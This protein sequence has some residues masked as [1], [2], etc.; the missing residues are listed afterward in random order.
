ML[1]YAAAFPRCRALTSCAVLSPV[2]PQPPPSKKLSPLDPPY[3]IKTQQVVKDK[4]VPPCKHLPC[5][6]P[7]CPP[8]ARRDRCQAQNCDAAAACWRGADARKAPLSQDVEDILGS[9]SPA[10]VVA[11]HK[12]GGRPL[13]EAIIGPHSP[14]TRPGYSRKKS[15]EGGGFFTG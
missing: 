12:N 5:P 15:E 9:T 4:V 14:Q 13:A 3:A 2:C 10:P 6:L 1:P 8:A 11:T 7:A